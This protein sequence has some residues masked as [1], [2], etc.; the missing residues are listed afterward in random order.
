[1]IRW[2]NTE[3]FGYLQLKACIIYYTFYTEKY[4]NLADSFL[5]LAYC[6]RINKQSSLCN[7]ETKLLWRIVSWFV[8]L[9]CMFVHLY[10]W[11]PND[12]THFLH[13]AHNEFCFRES[14]FVCFFYMIHAEVLP[15]VLLKH[16]HATK[17]PYI[18]AKLFRKRLLQHC[19]KGKKKEPISERMNIA[20]SL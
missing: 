20:I 6:L 15:D 19:W 14:K 5:I 13:R 3:R 1:M 2:Y 10:N 9:Y 12:T 18:S 11:S 8:K 16:M 17:Q 7:K 4:G